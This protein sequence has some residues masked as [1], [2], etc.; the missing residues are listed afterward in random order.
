MLRTKHKQEAVYHL[1]GL[2]D[3]EDV[4]KAITVAAP[5]KIKVSYLSNNV[6][7]DM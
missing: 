6:G 5:L 7:M 2:D 3:R 4:G 1:M